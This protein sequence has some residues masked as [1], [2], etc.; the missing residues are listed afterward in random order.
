[1]DVMKSIELSELKKLVLDVKET[2]GYDF[3]DYAVSSLQRRIIRFMN[4][5]SIDTVKNLVYRLIG[6][7]VFFKQFVLEITVNTT[8]MFRDPTMWTIL[9]DKILPGLKDLETI[10]IWHAGCSSGEEVYS[11]CI[12]LEE[13]GL[14]D[15]AKIYATDLNEVVM[16][17]AKQGKYSL[18]NMKLNSENYIKYGGKEALD[19]YC[20]VDT[21]YIIMNKDLLKNVSFKRF[22]LAT[23]HEPFLKFDII[24]CRNVMI[25]FNN[26]LQDKLIELFKNSLFAKAILVVGAQETIKM[27]TVGDA[28]SIV[29]EREKIFA[30]K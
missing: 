16:E 24:M 28:F 17:K 25:Y 18:R 23:E 7:E 29:D 8:E 12:L 6:D 5:Q 15:K 4:L 20:S 2:Y 10:R 9:K 21:E 30:L 1:M 13:E 26:T 11:M 22:D 3:S 14:L 27:S 19:K